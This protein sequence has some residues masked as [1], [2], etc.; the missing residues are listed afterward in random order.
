[1]RSTSARI[2]CRKQRSPGRA[3][4]SPSLWSVIDGAHPFEPGRPGVAEGFLRSAAN[5]ELVLDQA[6]QFEQVAVGQWFGDVY[7]AGGTEHAATLTQ[8]PSQFARW[9][10]VK[11]PHEDC[12]IDRG[13]SERQR[14]CAPNRITR[15]APPIVRN[16]RSELFEGDLNPNRSAAA[17]GELANQGSSIAADVVHVL[18]DGFD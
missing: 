8:S 13:L 5:I 7:R 14:L 12:D 3:P 17:G 1:M 9:H 6:S 15:A 4:A 16:R 10:V 11:R 18:A 2:G